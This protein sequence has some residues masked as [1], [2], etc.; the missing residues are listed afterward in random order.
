MKLRQEIEEDVV[1]TRIAVRTLN[2]NWEELTRQATTPDEFVRDLQKL[3][4]F[5]SADDI[6][7]MFDRD[8]KD[9]F[10]ATIRAKSSNPNPS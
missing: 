1:V 9:A 2:T 7:E 8:G 5:I 3:N 4:V 6:R 10:I